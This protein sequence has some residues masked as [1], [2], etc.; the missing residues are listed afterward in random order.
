MNTKNF[1]AELR[2]RNM[3]HDVTPDLEELSQREMLTAY[4]GFDPTADSLHIGSLLPIMMLKHLQMAG[5]RP[6]ALVGGGTGMIGDPS[7]KNEERQLLDR[8]TLYHN[9]SCIKKQ[10]ELFLDFDCG[11]HSALILNNYEW[12]GKLSLLD[13]LRDTCKHISI[14]YMMAKDSVKKRLE[15]GISFTEF[16]Y[17]ILQSYDFLHLFRT[18]N[19]ALQMGGADQWGNITT[20]IELIRKVEGKRSFALT[21]PL[22]TKNDG[23]KFGKTAAGNVWLD[24]KRTSPYQFYQY[25]INLSDAD[26]Q[27]M[28]ALFTLFSKAE[29]EALRK[30][31]EKAPEKR[32]LQKKIAEELTVQ[33][34][35]QED[36]EKTL[37]ATHSLFGRDASVEQL[38]SID[39]ALIIEIFQGIPQFKVR[40]EIW[41]KRSNWVNFFST[42][43]HCKI[44][45]SKGD[46]NRWLKSGGLR[47][48][49]QRID[50]NTPVAAIEPIHENL[51]IL[52]KGKKNYTLLQLQ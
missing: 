1:V 13:F 15:S 43:T 46:V 28:I 27:N 6:I 39:K 14:N 34:H 22:I 41:E 33:V 23:S 48:N 40:R 12:L 25:W 21:C 44:F 51:L 38:K 7:G 31:H 4:I 8:D 9:Q 36:L 16:S 18:H 26:A 11:N 17:Q 19:A 49:K 2:W 5:H 29:I 47:L 24:R 30:E 50:A 45:T 3:I 52:Q 10:L 42:D 35:S 20:G 32:I 37:K